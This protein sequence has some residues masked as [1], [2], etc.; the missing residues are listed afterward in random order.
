MVF[1]LRLILNFFPLK[2][3][4]FYLKNRK[5]WFEVD[6]LGW[7]IILLITL[8]TALA[9]VADHNI[10]ISLIGSAFVNIIF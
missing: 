2:K 7:E 9:L 1:N 6:G 8:L 3:K 4:L 10:V 5:E